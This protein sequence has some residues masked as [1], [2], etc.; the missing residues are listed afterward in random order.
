MRGGAR[1]GG[2]RR[3]RPLAAP[4]HRAACPTSTGSAPSAE[5]QELHPRA[6]DH[7]PRSLLLLRPPAPAPRVERDRLHGPVGLDGRLGRLRLGDRLDLRQHA[8]AGDARRRLRHRG[9]RPH[10]AARATRSTCSSASSS[11]A[12]PTSTA[13]SATARAS[14]TTRSRRSSSSSPISTRAATQGAAGAAPRGDGG[15][16]GPRHVPA[17]ALATPACR[18]TTTNLAKKLRQPGR[19]L[20]RLHAQR[21][22]PDAGGGAQGAEPR[23]RRLQVRHP[24]GVTRLIAAAAGRRRRPGEAPYRATTRSPASPR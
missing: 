10:R 7:H 8:G 4:A 19:A 14:C 15:L 3:P 11:A 13:P 5:P 20:L 1:A 18:A 24:E 22:A 12:A 21:A 23:R 17:G 9:R 6:E 16:R 2:A